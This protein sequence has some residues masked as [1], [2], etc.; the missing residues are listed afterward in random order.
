MKACLHTLK[1]AQ[2]LFRVRVRKLRKDGQSAEI[3]KINA[4]VNGQAQS[5]EQAHAKSMELEKAKSEV[6]MLELQAKEALAKKMHTWKMEEIRLEK[7]LTT[8]YKQDAED[9]IKIYNKLKDMSDGMV[10]SSQ[11]TPLT[12]VEFIGKYPYT[13]RYTL[14]GMGRLFLKGIKDE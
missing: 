7:Q 9:C 1:E 8:E 10:W 2:N 3:N 5:N 4:N 11:W 14:T 13:R 6:K 12:N